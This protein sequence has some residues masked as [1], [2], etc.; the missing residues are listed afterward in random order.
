MGISENN[1]KLIDSQMN[2]MI[3]KDNLRASFR[4]SYCT[5][6]NLQNGSTIYN[7]IC[8][9]IERELNGKSLYELLQISVDNID[10]LVW[11]NIF[12]YIK[13]AV[14][15][16]IKGAENFFRIGEQ[17]TLNSDKWWDEYHTMLGFIPC[18]TCELVGTYYIDK[19]NKIVENIC[20]YLET[21]L[22]KKVKWV[23]FSDDD[24]YE[25]KSKVTFDSEK[26]CYNDMRRA[27]LEKM[28]WNTEFDED[29]VPENGVDNFIGYVVKFSQNMIIHQSFSGVY[30]YKIV[31][32][33]EVVKHE[34][35]FTDEFKKWL[36]EYLQ[37]E[38][39]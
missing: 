13:K 24:A 27:V 4:A 18:D 11:G 25:D 6:M 33:D 10:A 28:K 34:D 12:N 26:D 32:E 5:K 31:G 39:Y 38:I 23:A 1:V 15:K 8:S 16:K 21:F 14:S 7:Y 29:L 22:P 17:A 19:Y 20:G 2:R 9:V 30:V 36:R 35:I 37:V 3:I